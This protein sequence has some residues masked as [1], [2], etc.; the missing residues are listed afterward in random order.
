MTESEE[1]PADMLA[2]VR[3]SFDRQGMMTTLG[4]EVTAVEAQWM[5]LRFSGC[6]AL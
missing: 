3:A 4:A 5:W 1:S 6:E 2:R